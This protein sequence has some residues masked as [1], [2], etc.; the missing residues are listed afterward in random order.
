MYTSAMPRRS[1]RKNLSSASAR[2]NKREKNT[3]WPPQNEEQLIFILID[4]VHKGIMPP[5]GDKLRD[6]HSELNN[7]LGGPIYTLKQVTGKVKRLKTSYFDFKTLLGNTICTGF[8]W[9]PTTNTVSGPEH[10]WEKLK[11]VRIC[12][13]YVLAH[14][15]AQ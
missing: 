8:G 4:R 13:L 7:K 11:S 5:F 3:V 15:I 2:N 10:E 1:P 12:S 9:D 6:V 14:L